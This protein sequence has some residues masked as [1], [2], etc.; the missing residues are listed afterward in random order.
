FA[1]II[2]LA[3]LQAIPPELDR[4]ARV[5]GA[6]PG[7]RFMAVTLPWLL[8][9]LLIVAIFETMVAFRAFDL[10]F[11]LTGGGPGRATTVIAWQT[12]IRAF[13]FRDFGAANAYSY[14][15]ALIT[16]AL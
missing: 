5:D 1:A 4:A 7:R 10:V 12:Y 6:R 11:T 9:P 2:F 13:R 14:L 15:I 16:M 8:H 3:A